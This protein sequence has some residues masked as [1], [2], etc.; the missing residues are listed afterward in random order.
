MDPSDLDKSRSPISENMNSGSEIVRQYSPSRSRGT[1]F[2]FGALTWSIAIYF[3]ST[4]FAT[5]HLWFV[6]VS[7]FL[8]SIPISL[9]GIYLSTIR[10]IHR[11]NIFAT[12]GKLFKLLSG[13]PLKVTLWITWSIFSSFFMLIQFHNYSPLEWI[14]FF[15]IAP[16]FW[17]T[18]LLL[19]KFIASELKP[20]LVTGMA[21]SWSRWIAPIIMIA[22]YL[23]VLVFYGDRP[24]Y[25]SLNDAIAAQKET[26]ANMTGSEL[27]HEA[28]QYLATYDG[29]KEYALGLMGAQDSLLPLVLLALG[30]FVV[31]YNA[32]GMLSA[33][34]IPRKEYRRVF[35]P[36]ECSDGT[37]PR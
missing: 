28:S 8:F 7:V 37:K 25:S 35:G 19:H 11:L 2:L 32:C 16:I 30:S 9:T 34:I 33:F 29:I 31:F 14:I 20:Y 4:R 17:L 15:L 23:V 1:W 13:R 12:H 18:F 24:N 3:L 22:V 10:Q 26:I 6:M 36:L 21:L 5:S 27:V